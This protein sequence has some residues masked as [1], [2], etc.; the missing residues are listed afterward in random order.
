MTP[1]KVLPLILQVLQEV[2]EMSGRPRH[3]L[4]VDMK[5]IGTL[6]GFDS[7]AGVEATVMI[8]EK[9]GCTLN[10]DSVFVSEDGKK[11]LT[12]K[13]VC[14]RVATLAAATKVNA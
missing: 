12:L 13:D 2:Q 14:E 9:L 5:P 8:E 11:A 6:D 10:V 4:T 1:E 7:L 3:P